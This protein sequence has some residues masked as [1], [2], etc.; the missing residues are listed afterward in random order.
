MGLHP[1]PPPT[2]FS[3]PIL[4]NCHAMRSLPKGGTARFASKLIGEREVIRPHK[5]RSRRP[6]EWQ[7]SRIFSDQHLTEATVLPSQIE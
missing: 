1:V 2:P 6:G 5:T 7:Y 3:P 4:P